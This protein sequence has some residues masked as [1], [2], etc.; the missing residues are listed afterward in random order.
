VALIRA[1]SAIS[2]TIWS[3]SKCSRTRAQVSSDTPA[4]SASLVPSSVSASAARSASLNTLA[5]RHAATR[6][7]RTSSSPAAAA[8]L[9]WMSTHQPQPLIWLARRFTRSRMVWGKGACSIA[10]LTL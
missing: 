5:W 3:S 2:A 1:I 8:S 6:W 9:V 4:A 7:M 10:R